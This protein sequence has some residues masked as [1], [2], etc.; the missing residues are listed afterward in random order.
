MD[1]RDLG[2]EL[3]SPAS[4]SGRSDRG[5]LFIVEE[6]ILVHPAQF[7]REQAR[8]EQH[9]GAGD[10]VDRARPEPP[11]G[12]VFPPRPWYQLLPRRPG[13]A[14][15]VA[16]PRADARPVG[17]AEPEA[18]DPRD[19]SARPGFVGVDPPEDPADQRRSS[20]T[21][22]G[23]RTRSQ[24]LDEAR[25][26][27]LTPAEKPSF[28]ARRIRRKAR[29]SGRGRGGGIGLAGIVVDDED[30]RQG[31]GGSRG[32]AREEASRSTSGQLR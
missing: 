24:G 7:F 15:E 25:Q 2:V 8:V 28:S 12:L 23:L 13:Q 19:P 14:R 27:A 22:S 18:D 1:H 4:P 10:P 20:T 9:A 26:P 30:L 31:P 11:F 17:V 16:R 3:D 21:T 6:E 5:H 32:M 29:G